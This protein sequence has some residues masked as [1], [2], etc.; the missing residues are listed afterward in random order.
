MV[1]PDSKAKVITVL[2]LKGGVGKTHTTWLM[3]SVCQERSKRILLVDTDTQGNLTGSFLPQPDGKPG[4]EAM[5]DPGAEVD[6]ATLVRQTAFS[7]IDLIPAS[8]SLAPF[9]EANQQTWEKAELHLALV[10]AVSQ[11]RANYD[12]IVFDCPPRLSLVSFAALC[13]DFDITPMEAADWGAQGRHLLSEGILPRPTRCLG[14]TDTIPDQN[15]LATRGAADADHGN[16]TVSDA[17]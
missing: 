16:S 2:N 3:A 6:P 12:Y 5:F 8:S 13:A 9:D 15:S 11:L 17:A 4:V 1:Q 7:H 10:D 14:R